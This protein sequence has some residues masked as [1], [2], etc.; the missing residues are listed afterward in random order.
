MSQQPRILIAGGGVVIGKNESGSAY[1]YSSRTV[2]PGRGTGRRVGTGPVTLLGDA[3][4]TMPPTGG[5][6]ANTAL[7][8]AAS[9]AAELRRETSLP[10]AVAAYEWV[11]LPRGFDG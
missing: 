9:L 2:H 8:D 3:I 7:Q 4:H 11:M 1:A 5:V 6:G 10:R